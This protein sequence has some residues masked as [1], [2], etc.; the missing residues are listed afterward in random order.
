MS[1]PL[2]ILLAGAIAAGRGNV[3]ASKRHVWDAAATPDH[4][5]VTV[6]PATLTFTASNPGTAPVVAASSPTF[7]SWQVVSGGSNWSLRVKANSP[8]FA[9][10][11]TVPV[12]AVTVSCASAS[13]LPAGGTSGCSGPFAL[14]TADTQVAGGSEGPT[15]YAY[16]VTI[17]FTLADSWKYIA[18][19]IPACSLSLTYKADVP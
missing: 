14:S 13:V 5:T 2:V 4:F 17:N 19:T 6:T 11:P 16:S 3:S 7:V 9:N 8:H 10:C 12:S 15:A 18:E 1:G